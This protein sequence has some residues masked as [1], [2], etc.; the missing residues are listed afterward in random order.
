MH[1]FGEC[2]ARDNAIWCLK[3]FP[4]YSLSSHSLG[5]R[6]SSGACLWTE[7]GV[8]IHWRGESMGSFPESLPTT[9]AD[10]SLCPPTWL[11]LSPQATLECLHGPCLWLGW[12]RLTDPSQRR[13]LQSM[14][15][16]HWSAVAPGDCRVGCCHNAI[17]AMWAAGDGP[18]AVKLG[19]SWN[20]CPSEEEWVRAVPWNQGCADPL[21]KHLRTGYENSHGLTWMW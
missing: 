17:A 15:P 6:S 7:P 12:D 21:A 9:K 18:Q 1:L 5:L 10:R 16:S 13:L 19:E 11:Y 2:V 4:F 20:C 3:W 14:G 8:K